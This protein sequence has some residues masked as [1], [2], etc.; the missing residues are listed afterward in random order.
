MRFQKTYQRKKSRKKRFKK[1]ELTQNGRRIHSEDW[2]HHQS[3]HWARKCNLNKLFQN[4]ETWLDTYNKGSVCWRETLLLSGKRTTCTK[5][6]SNTIPQHHYEDSAW[7]LEVSADVRVG[8]GDPV[9]ENLRT[10]ILVG[11]TVSWR[12]TAGACLGFNP[13]GLQ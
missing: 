11:W 7:V 5:Q 12:A 9:I 2:S 8:S 1:V 13:L 4:I 10:C 6:I 3:N